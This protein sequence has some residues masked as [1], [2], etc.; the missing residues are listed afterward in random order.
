MRRRLSLLLFAL[1]LTLISFGGIFTPQ[2]QAGPLPEVPGT[3]TGP[4]LAAAA[5]FVPED[6]PKVSPLTALRLSSGGRRR[7]TLPLISY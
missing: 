6:G 5:R 7:L 1:A 2:A 3:S 4:T